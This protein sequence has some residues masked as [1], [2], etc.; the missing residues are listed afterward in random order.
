[1]RQ[2]NDLRV[3]LFEIT[4]KC[5]ARCD[6]CGSRCEPGAREALPKEVWIEVLRDVAER[7]GTDVM[8]NITGGEPL[9]REDLFEITAEAQRLGFDWGMVTNGTLLTEENVARL[10]ETGMKTI[11]V[12]V[13]G[14]RE[15]HEALRHLP[16]SYDR[17]FEGIRRLRKADFLDE[18]Q[19]TFTA[20]RK[21][22]R[23]FPALYAE[24]EALG[25]D[26]VRTSVMDPIG[27]AKEHPEL[28]LR[29]EELET[30]LGFVRR[31]NR[32][33]RV[34]VVWGC[35]HYLKDKLPGRRFSCFAGIHAA[36]VLWNG[37]IFACPN[38]PRRPELIQ[39]SVPEE[40]FS[41]VWKRGFQPFRQRELP[42]ACRRCRYKTS[43]AGDSFHS[44]DF[45]AMRPLFCYRE[46]FEGAAPFAGAKA[47]GEREY[48]AYLKRKYGACTELSVAPDAPAPKVFLEPDAW[49][50]LRAFFHFGVRHPLS[51]Y[52]QQM[53]LVGFRLGEDYVIKYVFPSCVDSRA[54]DLATFTPETLREAERNVRII[55]KNF[56]RSDDAGDPTGTGL[57]FLGFAH[58]HPAQKE[59]TYSTGDEKLHRA[60][61]RRYGT[62]IG[63]LVNPVEETIGAYVGAR[64]EQ[65]DLRIPERK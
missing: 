28:L 10:K 13:D 59:L 43:C 46:L 17:I 36:S 34:P 3:L 51:A 15:T 65:A 40:R 62:Y 6:Q 11:T 63:I 23:E 26:S 35:C 12:S 57:R 18:L 45:D 8:L 61:R 27:R 21:N 7:I 1:M 54:P 19:V 48:R 29:G 38:I 56:S 53:G 44:F 47:D 60:L 55:Q 49:E 14:L 39:G 37:D 50:E 16:G 31:A 52:E 32:T 5:N 41:E 42:E 25:I 24:L 4:Q 30:Y 64:I 22:Y 9:L 33:G 2:K 58:S 20:N